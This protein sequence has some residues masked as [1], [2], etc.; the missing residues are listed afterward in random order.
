MDDIEV[1]M[2]RLEPMK[3]ASFRVM[4]ENPEE[5]AAKMLVDW[6]LP[7]G[8]LEDFDEHP[9]YG[10]NS[11]DP[12]PGDVIR[13]YE[14]WI[15]VDPGFQEEGVTLKDHEGGLYAVTRVHVKEPWEDIPAAWGK[16]IAWVE[17]SEHEMEHRICLEKTPDLQSEGE[18]ILDLY[19]PVKG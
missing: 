10:F 5:E 6:A 12:K 8:L 4:S 3:V 19:C 9:V 13:G 2:V 11:P 7:R 16:L 1:E 18:F 17:A 15:R 14:F